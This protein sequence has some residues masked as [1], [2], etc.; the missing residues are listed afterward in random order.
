MVTNLGDV[1][2]L[3]PDGAEVLVASG[4]LAEVGGSRALPTDVTVW[5][6]G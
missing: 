3:L 4:E 6:R 5:L 2:V 1:P